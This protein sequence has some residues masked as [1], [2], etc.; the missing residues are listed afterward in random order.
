MKS[1]SK[2][3]LLAALVVPALTECS[4]AERIKKAEAATSQ[5]RNTKDQNLKLQVRC[6]TCC[7]KCHPCGRVH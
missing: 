7:K 6:N 1:L 5:M 4:L 2:L 3:A